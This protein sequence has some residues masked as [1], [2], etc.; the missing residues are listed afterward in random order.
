MSVRGQGSNHIGSDGRT[1]LIVGSTDYRNIFEYFI[2][3]IEIEIEI[4]LSIQ[5]FRIRN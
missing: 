2:V 5:V 3:E 4:H 1:I